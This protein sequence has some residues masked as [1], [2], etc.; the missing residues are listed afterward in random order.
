MVST[1]FLQLTV[2]ITLCS[3]CSSCI[4]FNCSI[5]SALFFL[6]N[7]LAFR[8]FNSCLN[9]LMFN[10]EKSTMLEL[11]LVLALGFVL[12]PVLRLAVRGASGMGPEP[13][14]EIS[15]FV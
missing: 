9:C 6:L 8:F 4:C 15:A 11:V 14:L 5:S 1:S 13:G 3:Y 7:P 12:V 10:L 2:T